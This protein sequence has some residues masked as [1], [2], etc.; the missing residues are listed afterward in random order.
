MV[1]EVQNSH[2]W[3][4]CP[5]CNAAGVFKVGNLK[6]VE[7]LQFSTQVIR[8]TEEPEL[9]RCTKCMSCF[10]QNIIPENISKSLYV[11]GD[12]GDRWVSEVFEQQKMGNTI[13]CLS[14]LLFPGKKVLDV[15]CNTGELLD[16][17]KSR[18]CQPAGLEY[19]STSR[20]ILNRKGIKTFASF[21][22]V[23]NLYDVI[24]A[25]DIIEHLYNVPEF[26]EKCKGKLTENGCLVLLT[27]NVGSF[28]ARVAGGKWWYARFPE[29]IVF[30]SRKYFEEFSG[31]DVENCLH[32]YASVSFKYSPSQFLG[33]IASSLLKWSYTGLP[34]LGPDHVL[35][36]L[37]K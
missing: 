6:Y 24:T 15:G 21:D 34:S 7:P 3:H 28:S 12:A 19:S 30:P 2:R 35:V 16:Y 18:G 22:E 37:R 1:I 31:Y 26:L 13:K 8:L 20:D 27:G 29:H 9:W 17:A 25:F 36:V 10:A 5:L 32:T 11:N 23:N 33:A 4:R 14:K